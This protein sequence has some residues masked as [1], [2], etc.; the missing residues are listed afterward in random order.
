MFVLNVLDASNLICHFTDV[1]SSNRIVNRYHRYELIHEVIF[2]LLG[3]V[4]Q[5][6]SVWFV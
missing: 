6:K 2:Y 3:V 5:W 1:N 4:L